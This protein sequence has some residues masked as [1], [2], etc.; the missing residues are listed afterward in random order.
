LPRVPTSRTSRAGALMQMA[1]VASSASSITVRCLIS[2][3]E[4]GACG[5][6]PRRCPRPRLALRAD[7]RGALADAAQR[8]AEVRRPAHERDLVGPLVDVVR[9]VGRGQDLRLVDV[10]HLRAPRAPALRR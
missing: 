5:A 4:C 1:A 7:H 10:I 9:L 8:F 6:R 3:A 2:R